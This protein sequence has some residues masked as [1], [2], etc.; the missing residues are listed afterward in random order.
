MTTPAQ[1]SE[2][3]T[4]G[5]SAGG[6]VEPAERQRGPVT[7]DGAS[8]LESLRARRQMDPLY[9]THTFNPDE[10]PDEQAARIERQLAGLRQLEELSAQMTE[11][12]QQ[13]WSDAF[14][15][16]AHSRREHDVTDA[17]SRAS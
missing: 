13:D 14:E 5:T 16:I 10:T 1:S 7:A 9:G 8:F 4:D 15:S 3:G 6:A 2:A 17:E 12:E 11:D